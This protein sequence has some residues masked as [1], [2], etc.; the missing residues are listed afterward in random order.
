MNAWPRK[1][2]FWNSCQQNAITSAFAAIASSPPTVVWRLQAV[3]FLVFPI[4]PDVVDERCDISLK[5]PCY[6]ILQESSENEESGYSIILN[7]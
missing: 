2:L 6:K 5:S 4:L 1:R 3:C 7:F